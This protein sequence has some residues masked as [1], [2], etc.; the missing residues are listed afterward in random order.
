VR[1]ADRDG[2]AA[3]RADAEKKPLPHVVEFFTAAA[4][5]P[6]AV[7]AAMR[8]RASTSRISTA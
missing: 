5:P 2:D 7:L 6:E 3:E 1:R 8:E 4:P